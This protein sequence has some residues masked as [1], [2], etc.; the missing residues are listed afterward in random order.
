MVAALAAE[1]RERRAVG[2]ATHY[3]ANYV[4]PAWAASL[5]ETTQ[6][7]RHIFYQDADY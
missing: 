2:S 3:H 1:D 6:L 7:G 4:Q 5:Q